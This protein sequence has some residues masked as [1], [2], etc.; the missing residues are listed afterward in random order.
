MP[1]QYFPLTGRLL[2][3]DEGA[4][5]VFDTDEEMLCMSPDDFKTGSQVVPARTASSDG[6]DGDQVMVDIE[7]EYY[8]ADVSLPGAFVVRGMMRSTATSS[9]EDLG[10]DNLWRQASG[11]HLD[12]LDGV[13]TTQV[14]QSDLGGYNRV[15]TMG[16]YTLYINALGHLVLNE[17]IVMRC[18]D[19]G[20]PPTKYNRARKETTIQFRLMIGFFHGADFGTTNPG[21]VI[22]DTWG[23]Y[24]SSHTQSTS[25][26]HAFSG[27]EC[28]VAIIC[29]T[30]ALPTVIK[31]GG[32][33][34]TVDYS[35]STEIGSIVV[36][37]VSESVSD[38]LNVQV[39]FGA[40][41]FF[42]VVAFAGRNLGTAT[43][44][45]A[46]VSSG[47]SV[48][49]AI[50]AGA[51]K[52]GIGLFQGI[53]QSGSVIGAPTFGGMEPPFWSYY[54]SLSE[55]NGDYAYAGVIPNNSSA[56]AVSAGAVANYKMF[57]AGVMY[58]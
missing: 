34:A 23:R 39:N 24:G 31:I 1:I 26:L 53:K 57:V 45:N 42:A 35:T 14:P 16:G 3:T 2:L 50:S 25:F 47:T 38:S 49:A 13:S 56:T 19:S 54:T 20:G 46:G 9:P 15:A 41:R 43:G 22:T 33:N 18:R 37:R 30:N 58:G 52:T 6:V 10:V 11:T 17:R 29:Q 27:R 55:G 32:V 4:R 36:A 21:I 7:T 8:L 51:G 12:I 40:S 5:V 48:S 44:F 28:G